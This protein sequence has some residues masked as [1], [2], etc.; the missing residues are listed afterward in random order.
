[1]ETLA[2]P[3]GSRLNA[4]RLANGA[5]EFHVPAGHSIGWSL[6]FVF[7]FIIVGWA[8]SV[9][10]KQRAAALLSFGLMGLLF[11]CIIAAALLG[12]TWIVASPQRLDIK[13]GMFG[14]TLSRRMVKAGD[15]AEI[16]IGTGNLRAAT[17]LRFK[18]RNGTIEHICSATGDA[19]GM[20][21]LAAELRRAL[22]VG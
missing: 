11:L 20:Q 3:A 12:E 19:P 18:R 1:M 22:R 13:W 9:A 8:T 5:V 7:Y 10:G 15:I 21:W 6:M 4:R 14:G 17:A 2:P 16:D